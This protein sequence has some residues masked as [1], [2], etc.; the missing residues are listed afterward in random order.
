[1]RKAPPIMVTTAAPAIT[2]CSC[3]TT[4]VIWS[5]A[6]FAPATCTAPTDGV[7]SWVP[8]V[9]R[10]SARGTRLYFR[11]DAAFASPE[12]YD[13]LEVEG[14]LYAVRLPANKVLQESITHLLKRPVGRPRRA[15]AGITPASAI[16]REAGTSPAASSP[17][18]S[19]IPA[20][21][22]QELGS[23]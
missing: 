2:R 23:S 13:Y 1:M 17:R 14:V 11:G 7:M 20:N 12:I 22:I 9:E 10:Y 18:S 6:P 21:S 19:G 5:A 15:C 16:R 4:L 3:S 8:V